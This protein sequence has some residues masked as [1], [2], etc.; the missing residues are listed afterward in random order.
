MVVIGPT[1]CTTG[2]RPG[3]AVASVPGCPRRRQL[4]RGRAMRSATA[5][6]SRRLL[7]LRLESFREPEVEPGGASLVVTGGDDV[8]RG[9]RS[10]SDDD[11][12][13][14]G[15][16]RDDE[17]GVAPRR[18]TSTQPGASSL[19]ISSAAADSA[20][21]RT[22]QRAMWHLLLTQTSSAVP[23]TSPRPAAPA[24]SHPPP[25]HPCGRDGASGWLLQPV[26]R[27]AHPYRQTRRDLPGKSTG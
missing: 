5:P 24:V 10:Q 15:W 6:R 14:V 12:G 1:R 18:R 13:R 11:A 23:D 17:V 4:R 25:A 26:A 21:S 7:D 3:C 22:R 8:R 2:C 27:S 20:S 9:R 16:L 19:V